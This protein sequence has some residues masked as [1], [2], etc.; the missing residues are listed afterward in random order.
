[1][2]SVALARRGLF[3]HEEWLFLH[4]ERLFLREEGCSCVKR[5]VLARRGWFLSVPQNAIQTANRISG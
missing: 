2:K 4:E 3:L 1:M 5:V